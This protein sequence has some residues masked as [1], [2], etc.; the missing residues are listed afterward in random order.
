M[1][2]LFVLVPA[3]DRHAGGVQMTTAKLSAW[4]AR[5]GHDVSVFSF[6]GGSAVDP[7]VTLYGPQ[8][9]RNG[10]TEKPLDALGKV[11]DSIRPE[12]VINQMP[13][14]AELAVFLD[15]R[16]SEFLLLGCLRNTLFSVVAN[17]EAY[18]QKLVPGIVT[19]WVPASML[20]FGLLRFHRRQ[21]ARQLRQI[22]ARHDRFVMF[23]PPNLD[24][25][26]YFVPDFDP[27]S[28]AL[29]PNS[30]P[31][32]LDE[33]PEKEKRILWLGRLCNQQKRCQ[34]LVPLWQRLCHTLPDWRLDIVGD[35]PARSELEAAFAAADLVNYEFHGKQAPDPFFHR[36]AIFVMTSA[37]EG[38][39]NTLIE[40][41]SH[42]AVP[43]IFDNY[44]IASWVV[45]SGDNGFLIQPFDIPAMAG[46]IEELTA[47]PERCQQL[48]TAALEN[49][50][51]FQ[52]NRVGEQWLNLFN[53][54]LS[55]HA[56]PVVR[57]V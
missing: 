50:R 24:E 56:E 54:L 7:G 27:S 31:R 5:Q 17:L 51:R 48:A 22:L 34:L 47:S 30:I 37:Y 14:L 10:S 16:R 15:S 12:V 36:S 3:F 25:L 45:G 40:A 6:E 46:C 41:Q 43:V 18:R 8:V 57:P 2:I 9:S 26:R 38:F 53:E 35:G 42:G 39:P 1:R 55:D 33:V 19:R 44:P 52:I 20:D 49:A 13:Y 4:F 32:V 28:V 29:I 11:M 23:G 21:H